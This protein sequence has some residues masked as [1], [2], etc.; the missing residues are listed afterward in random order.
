MYLHPHARITFCSPDKKDSDYC[1]SLTKESGLRTQTWVNWISQFH[2]KIEPQSQNI[3][4]SSSGKPIFWTY[5]CH[6]NC[7]SPLPFY[8][9]VVIWLYPEKISG[10]EKYKMLESSLYWP[11]WLMLMCFSSCVVYKLYKECLAE[12]LTPLW[13]TFQCSGWFII[14]HQPNSEASANMYLL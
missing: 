5:T 6:R 2:R 9:L 8:Q 7:A 3:N 11:L 14:L 13:L 10:L 4:F 1:L 12:G